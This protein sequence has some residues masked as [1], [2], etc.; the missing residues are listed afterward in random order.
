MNRTSKRVERLWMEYQDQVLKGCPPQQIR[1]MR[2]AFYT[3]VFVILI[4][5]KS[6]ID[7]RVSEDE[8]VDIFESIGDECHQFFNIR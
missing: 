3:G 5:L 6:N 4:H 1:E 8:G 2:K 7:D